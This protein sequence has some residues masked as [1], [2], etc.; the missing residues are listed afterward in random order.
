MNFDFDTVVPGGGTT[1]LV[2]A[3][4]A[5]RMGA[6]VL[7]VEQYG[8]LGGNATVIPGWLGFHSVSGDRVVGGVPFELVGRLQATGAAT[9]FERDPICGSV[10]GVDPNW[11]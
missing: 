6:R 9:C 4:S 3:V 11:W 7:L 5:A 10:V 2:A 1:G 8:F